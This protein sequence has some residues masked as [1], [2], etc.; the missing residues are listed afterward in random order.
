MEGKEDRILPSKYG[1]K[2]PRVK[3]VSFSS[4]QQA[5]S[6]TSPE[7]MDR[8]TIQSDERDVESPRFAPPR[9]RR[10][11]IPESPLGS[12][13][14][15][16]HQYEEDRQGGQDKQEAKD[17]QCVEDEQG[18]KDDR[19][20]K[21][22]QGA[23]AEKGMEDGQG[24]EDDHD[25][26]NPLGS[27]PNAA[28]MSKYRKDVSEIAREWERSTQEIISL[29]DGKNREIAR[30]RALTQK[31]GQLISQLRSNATKDAEEIQRLR[32]VIKSM[33]E[34]S[35]ESFQLILNEANKRLKR[36]RS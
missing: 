24:A 2:Y 6:S 34:D 17:E 1:Y 30:L 28:L 11:G 27:A 12:G 3:Q 29:L 4:S 35:N 21:D 26:E 10:A 36:N 19:G 20:A 9:P 8:D 18:A 5:S 14:F 25:H 15:H 31:E 32:R 16:I 7:I 33:Q 22:E 13:C 23:E